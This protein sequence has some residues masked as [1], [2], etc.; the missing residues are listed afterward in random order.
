MKLSGEYTFDAPQ[1]LVWEALQD[2]NVLSSV[3]P[4]A[5]DFAEVGENSYSGMLNIKVGPVQGDFQGKIELSDIVPPQSYHIDVNGQGAPGF[6][7]AE[8]HMELTGQGNKTHM[9]YEGEARIGGRIASVGQ[10]LLDASARSIVRQSLDGLNEY[11]QLQMAA[12]EQAAATAEEDAVARGGTEGAA[13][14]ESAAPQE[15]LAYRA[16][17]QSQV[18]LNVIRDVVGDMVP[19]RYRPVLV[20]IIVLLIV[21]LVYLIVR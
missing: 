9:A 1:E 12:Q 2:P 19:P 4:G 7:K 21:A 15:E 17:S 10:R 14:E 13:R 20:A 18:A 8:G 5:H 11:L 6:V 16:P 3:M